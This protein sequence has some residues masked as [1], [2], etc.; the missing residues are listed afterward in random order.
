[1]ETHQTMQIMRHGNSAAVVSGIVLMFPR[2]YVRLMPTSIVDTRYSLC[3]V[4][5]RLDVNVESIVGKQVA[6]LPC[7]KDIDSWN[8]HH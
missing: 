5:A 3:R 8:I 2:P 6:F 1:M 4:Q 7:H